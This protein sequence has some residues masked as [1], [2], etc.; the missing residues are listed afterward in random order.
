MIS[1]KFSMVL[2]VGVDKSI[3]SAGELIPKWENVL[4]L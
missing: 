3:W 4:A 2:S 1:L